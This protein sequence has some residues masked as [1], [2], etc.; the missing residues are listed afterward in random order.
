M[1]RKQRRQSSPLGGYHDRNRALFPDYVR[2]GALCDVDGCGA[3][4]TSGRTITR[5]SEDGQHLSVLVRLCRPHADAPIDELLAAMPLLGPVD[6]PYI[7]LR[8]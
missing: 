3:K 4:V 5:I 7:D 2:T 6:A 8:S 1:N